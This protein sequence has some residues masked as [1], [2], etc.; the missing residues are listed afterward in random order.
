MQKRN[1]TLIA[2]MVAVIVTFIFFFVEP[3][4]ANHI[5]SYLFFMLGLAGLWVSSMLLERQKDSYP[6]SI[7][8][9]TQAL[10][11]SIWALVIL[12]VNLVLEQAF[13]WHV[14]IIWLVFIELLVIILHAIRVVML[15]GGIGYIRTLGRQTA[16]KVSFI[17]GLTLEVELM[18]ERAEDPGLRKLLGVLRDQFRY[19][20]PM[21]YDSL[22]DLER[23][24]GDSVALLK[25]SV[26]AKDVQSCGEAV[27]KTARLVTERNKRCVMLK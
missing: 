13:N 21:S 22:E 27:E 20:D 14:P 15:A 6:W 3:V 16:E 5:A 12:V 26:M 24:I 17:R 1:I 9:P 8:I 23:E 4:T 2:A 11:F 19:S 25:D 7:S 18:M 10:H